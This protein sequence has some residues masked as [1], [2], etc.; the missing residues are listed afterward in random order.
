MAI[1]TTSSN[2]DI[3]SYATKY[4]KNGEVALVTVNKGSTEKVIT[5]S[6]DSNGVGNKYYIYTFTG[7]TE[8]AT[9]PNVYINGNGPDFFQVGPYDELSTIKADGYTIDGEIKFVSPAYSVQMILIE[10]GTNHIIVNDSAFTKVNSITSGSFKLNQNYPNPVKSSTLISY[11][12]QESSFVTLKVFDFQGREIKTVVNEFQN[13]GNHS[14]QFNV[15]DLQNGVYFYR[16]E[17]GQYFENKKFIVL[18]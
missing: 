7:G 4:S 6:T 12:L 8:S 18:K 9:S 10:P 17:T 14:V 1:S 15:S 16:I 13:Q 5:V 2:K 3:L 11:E